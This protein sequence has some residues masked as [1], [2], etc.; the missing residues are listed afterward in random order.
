MCLSDK[1]LSFIMLDKFLKG[2]PYDWQK[3]RVQPKAGES[4][5]CKNE[6]K[7]YYSFCQ[8]SRAVSTGM[9]IP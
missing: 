5:E 8:E 6:G 4:H 2:K 9:K 7:R 3:K 1:D